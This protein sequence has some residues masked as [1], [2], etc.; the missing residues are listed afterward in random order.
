MANSIMAMFTLYTTYLHTHRS[1]LTPSIALGYGLPIT[2]LGELGLSV[3][4]ISFTK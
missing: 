2:L 1:T 4:N 3:K